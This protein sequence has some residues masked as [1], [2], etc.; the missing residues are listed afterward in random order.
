MPIIEAVAAGGISYCADNTAMSE[1]V[2]HVHGSFDANDPDQIKATL[3]RAF[4]NEARGRS[5]AVRERMLDS[6]SWSRSAHAM[7]EAI[8]A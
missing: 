4:T 3:E 1:L 2:P 5:E 8:R 6:F 7:V